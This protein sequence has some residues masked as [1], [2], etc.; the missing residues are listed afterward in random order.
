VDA[1]QGGPREHAWKACDR[2]ATQRGAAWAPRAG[3]PTGAA[4]SVCSAVWGHGRASTTRTAVLPAPCGKSPQTVEAIPRL[5]VDNSRRTSR[6]PRGTRRHVPLISTTDMVH[7]PVTVCP[8]RPTPSDP[9]RPRGPT[10]L[11]DGLLR[12]YIAVSPPRAATGPKPYPGA[13]TVAA[14]DVVT[15]PGTRCQR[16]DAGVHDPRS[17][18]NPCIRL[19]PRVAWSSDRGPPSPPVGPKDETA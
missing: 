3:P 19:R 6:V 12:H 8:L 13:P 2:G 7:L 14:H 4:T 10:A 1:S 11:A 5:P 17:V 18:D 9:Y 15:V 16:R